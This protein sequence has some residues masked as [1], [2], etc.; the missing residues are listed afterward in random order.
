[1]K[2][3]KEMYINNYNSKL[4]YF[5]LDYKSVNIMTKMW[6]TVGIKNKLII[7]ILSLKGNYAK[8]I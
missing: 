1:M 5:F 3:F 7:K 4:N 6:Y 8:L 2:F